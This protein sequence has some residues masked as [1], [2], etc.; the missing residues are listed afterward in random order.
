MRTI[1]HIGDAPCHGRWY[2][3]LDDYY[4]EGDPENRSLEDIFRCLRISKR[5]RMQ[6]GRAALLAYTNQTLKC[7][8]IGVLQVQIYHFLHLNTSTHKMLEMFK[9][10]TS[11]GGSHNWITDMQM[12]EMRPDFVKSVLTAVR[13]SALRLACNV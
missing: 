3:D 12:Q 2:H 10:I 13:T 7:C 5:V 8:F 6:L 9:A 1:I 11:R 4:P